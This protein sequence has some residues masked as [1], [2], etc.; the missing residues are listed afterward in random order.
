MW[1]RKGPRPVW[2]RPGVGVIEKGKI[3]GTEKANKK[4]INY[5]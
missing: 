3:T 5:F 2:C 4:A 1:V